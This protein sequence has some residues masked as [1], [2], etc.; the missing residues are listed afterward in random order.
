MKKAFVKPELK[1][2]QFEHEDIMN[3]VGMTSSPDIEGPEID[4]WG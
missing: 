4:P 2:T 1:V 3:G